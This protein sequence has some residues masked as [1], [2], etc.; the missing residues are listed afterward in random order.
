MHP[1]RHKILVDLLDLTLYY[2][3]FLYS[4][5]PIF[6]GRPRNINFK[7]V[8]RIRLKLATW[9]ASLLSMAG[10]VQLVKSVVKGM[11]VHCLSIDKWPSS[12]IK[13]I[14]A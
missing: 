13:N 12:I 8:E 10:R 5:S 4:G 1:S 11:L 6:I 2:P 3:P 7:I 9:K 14:E